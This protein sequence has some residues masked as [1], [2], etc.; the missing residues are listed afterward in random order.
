VKAI[1][2][3]VEDSR[4]RLGLD[5]LP[6]VLF[7]RESDARYLEVLEDLK[8]RGWL[9]HAGV[10][11]DNRPGPAVDYARSGHAAALQIPANVLDYRHQASGVFREAAASG[12]AVF[13]RSVYL[14]GLL[15]MPEDDIPPALRDVIPV[16]RRLSAIA[17]GAGLGLAELALRAMLSREGITC[18]LT[19]VDTVGQIREN[20]ALFNRGPLPA[21]M[22]A[23]VD[24]A[25]PVLPETILT[26]SLWPAPAVMGK[27]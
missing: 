9:R 24:A 13:V 15:V 25:V 27:R 3:S 19:G 21:D 5:C 16:R 7:H 11:C 23:A 12:V 20:I 4:R 18:L 8:A 2:Q 26:P 6:V 1:E 22:I 10:S 14:Q 17:S